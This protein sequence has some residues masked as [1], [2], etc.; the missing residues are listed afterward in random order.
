MITQPLVKLAAELVDVRAMPAF[1]CRD[2]SAATE[3]LGMV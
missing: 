1:L 2:R 3:S